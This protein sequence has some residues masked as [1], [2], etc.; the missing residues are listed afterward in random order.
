MCDVPWCSLSAT[1]TR[2]GVADSHSCSCVVASLFS[3]SR[4]GLL[5]TSA[6]VRQARQARRQEEL[7]ENVGT[8]KR[9]NNKLS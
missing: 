6:G 9:V 2:T 5:G 4:A 3:V 8:T 7:C 1:H